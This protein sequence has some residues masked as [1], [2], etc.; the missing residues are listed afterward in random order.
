VAA[1]SRKAGLRCRTPLPSEA[2]TPKRQDT[3]TADA[4]QSISLGMR[5]VQK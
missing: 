5:R 2:L 1:G 3:K 4:P